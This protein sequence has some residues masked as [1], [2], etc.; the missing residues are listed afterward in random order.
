MSEPPPPT[1]SDQFLGETN[2]PS[3]VDNPT[4]SEP[5]KSWTL[6]QSLLATVALS[7]ISL[8]ALIVSIYQTRVL[9]QQQE[10]MAAQQRIM[11]ES[12]KA[13]LWPNV[14]IDRFRGYKDGA[15][16]DSLEFVIV[17]SGTGPA[18]IEGAT[19]QYEGKYARVWRELYRLT[20][21]P[22][23]VSGFANTAGFSSG[24]LPIGQARTILGL[25]FNQSLMEHM[26]RVE[27]EGFTITIC[28]RSV[29]N[30]YW[31]RE[32]KYGRDGFDRL[33]PVDSCVIA[34]S[35]MFRN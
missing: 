14:E 23:T 30:D 10:V 21:L 3:P 26:E 9:A 8:C 20:N 6:D 15:T 22:D 25:S 13:Q 31:L 34:D 18:I 35:I 12:A 2:D 33:T 32:H 1:P 17:N 29:F 28:Y 27:E 7:I 11:T 16:I 4:A 19:V 5:Q 24:T